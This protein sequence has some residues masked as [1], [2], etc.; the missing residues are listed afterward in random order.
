MKF[1]G[2][3]SK[4][5]VNFLRLI[6]VLLVVLVLLF[7]I[8]WRMN[9]LF[10]MM[11]PEERKDTSITE[12]I[13]SSKEQIGKISSVAKDASEKTTLLKIEA[14][15]ADSV[16]KRLKEVGLI[17]DAAAFSNMAKRSGMARYIT[18]G[19]YEIPEG[20]SSETILK[21]LTETGLQKA[22]RTVTIEIPEGATDETIA[23]VVMKENLV[24]D[25]ATF[26]QMLR[27]AGAVPQIKPGGYQIHAPITATNLLNTL[28]S[29]SAPQAPTQ[30]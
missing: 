16:A 30:E 12:E 7:I 1:N 27:D 10:S 3:V 17:N 25:R 26:L 22:T 23:D 18:E 14:T 21:K 19:S 24:A 4:A 8:K 11:T 13:R 15:D 29:Q 20:A 28:M 6:V 9:H 5:F 2:R